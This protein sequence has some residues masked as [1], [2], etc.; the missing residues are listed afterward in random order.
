MFERVS[1]CFGIEAR[2]PFLDKQV[3]QEFLWLS[4]SLKNKEFKQCI[5]QY[6]RKTNFPFFNNSSA[7]GE[8]FSTR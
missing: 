1:G 7:V 3:V 8:K 4:D 2:Y 6:M 5:A